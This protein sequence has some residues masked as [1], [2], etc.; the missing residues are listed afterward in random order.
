MQ[1]LELVKNAL[2]FS[3]PSPK[4]TMESYRSKSKID[5]KDLARALYGQNYEIRHLIYDVIEK[6]QD[7]FKQPVITESTRQEARLK[8]WR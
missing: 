5:N 6:N 8:I 7:L 3:T 2:V 4:E 1:R